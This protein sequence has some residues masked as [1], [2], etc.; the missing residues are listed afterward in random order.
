MNSEAAE[1]ALREYVAIT[2]DRDNRVINAHT[3]GITKNRI[4]TITGISRV[5][6]DKILKEHAMKTAT[7]NLIWSVVRGESPDSR[8]VEPGVAGI[9]I[10]T[11]ILDW[12]E[13]WG[14]DENDPDVYLLVTPEDEAGEVQGEI[15]YTPHPASNEEVGLVWAALVEQED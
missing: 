3:A 11:E 13:G 8:A 12:A 2:D 10:P 15:A 5:T 1:A 4:H 14:L 7:A 6:I 9:N